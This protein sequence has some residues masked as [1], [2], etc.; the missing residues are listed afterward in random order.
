MHENRYI[1]HDIVKVFALEAEPGKTRGKLVA[2]LF[3]GDRVS[4]TGEDD[5]SWHVMMS[6]REWDES[7]KQY[8]IKEVPCK[9]SKRVALRA[10]PFVLKARIVDVGQG[11]GAIVETPE[12]DLILIDGGEESHMTRYLNASFAHVLTTESLDASAIIVT[13]GDA[14]HYAGLT[15]LA[16]AER[17]PD[18]PLLTASH[19]FHNGLVKGPSSGEEAFGETTE[20]DGRRWVIELENDLRQVPSA[21]MNRPFQAWKTA[22]S[23]LRTRSGERPKVR[24]LEYGDDDAF[25]FLQSEKL[26]VSVLGP[27]VQQVAGR[28]ALPYLRTPGSSSY[29]DSHTVNGHSIVL[30][31]KYGNV[32]FLF[33]ADLNEESEEMLLS[34]VRQDNASLASEIFKV[35]HHGSADFSPRMMEAVRPVVSIVSCGDESRAKEYIHPRAGLVGALGK[36]SRASVERPLVYVTEMV[37]FFQR[38]KGEFRRYDKIQFGIVHIRTDGERVLV[39][40]HSGRDDQKES[41]VFHVDERG[42]VRFQS[43]PR[44]A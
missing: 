2:T 38:V 24:R 4:V 32:A 1:D 29:S 14:D 33:G 11:D 19:V 27:Q 17:A 3:W 35:P 18:E 10:D 42:D 44:M 31:M 5:E 21:R 36:Y 43:K 41:Y 26:H 9:L 37:A 16:A 8:E 30:R 6:R 15:A 13:H 28:P 7:L 22:L 20:H 23:K 39:A 40:T 34:R 12:G 25:D